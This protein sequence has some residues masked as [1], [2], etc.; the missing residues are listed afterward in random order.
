MNENVRLLNTIKDII[1]NNPTLCYQ[2]F[3]FNQVKRFLK[4]KGDKKAEKRLRDRVNY[5]LQKLEKHEAIS[6]IDTKSRAVAYKLIDPAKLIDLINSNAR[7]KHPRKPFNFSVETEEDREKLKHSKV[8]LI[9]RFARFSE[10]WYQAAKR[11][12]TKEVIKITDE[13]VETLKLCFWAW[14]DEAQQKLLLFRTPDGEIEVKDYV[15]RFTHESKAKEILAKYNYAFNKAKQQYDHGVFLTITL[16]PIFPLRIQQIALSF[17]AHRIKAYLRR[18]YGFNPPHILANEPQKNL[19]AHKHIIIFGIDFIMHKNQLT[20]YLEKQLTNLLSKLG[21]HYKRTIHKKAD[22]L[23]VQAL[24]Q[25]GKK[26]L[27]KYNKWKNKIQEKAKQEG[28]KT[29]YTGPINFITRIY[30]QGRTFSFENLP[31]DAEKYLN[32]MKVDGAG[33]TVE[34]Y[35]RKYMVKNVIEASQRTEDNEEEVSE[36]LAWYWL[37]RSQFF[38]CSPILRPKQQKPPPAGWEFIGA[39]HQET[40]IQILESQQVSVKTF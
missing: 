32:D 33:I 29:T 31:P 4:F 28:K 9:P 8:L 5:Y 7:P 24:N 3:I 20:L 38:T 10:E 14:K 19:S 18:K 15:T 21:E 1:L 35:I 17:I 34:D 13:D 36:L 11:I 30:I 40:V 22:E 12:F 2:A 27:K 26:W 37:T 23:T 6:R 16:P 39:F 25:L